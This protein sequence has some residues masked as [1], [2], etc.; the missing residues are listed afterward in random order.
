M[1]Y[2]DELD[3]FEAER[4]LQ[5]RREY[6]DVFGLFRYCVLTPDGTYLCNRL[7]FDRLEVEGRP[8]FSLELEDVWIWDVNRPQRLLQNVKV[9]T[10]G[11]VTVEEIRSENGD[12]LLTSDDISTMLERRQDPGPEG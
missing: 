11:D 12:S 5:V 8:F 10:S 7:T 2:L 4:E 3:E 1:G 9:H 6:E